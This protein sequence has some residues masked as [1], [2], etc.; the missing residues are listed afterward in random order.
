MAHKKHTIACVRMI[1]RLGDPTTLLREK[2]AHRSD[3]AD[4]IGTLQGQHKC[5][6]HA[7]SPNTRA[8]VERPHRQRGSCI[9]YGLQ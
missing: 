9:D 2:A 7:N 5:I 3:D 6:G 8:A 1:V 4:A